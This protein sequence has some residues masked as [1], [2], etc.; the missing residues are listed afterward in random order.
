[1]KPVSNLNY[2]Y[3]VAFSNPKC[4]RA[5][6]KTIAK[7]KATSILEIGLG[8]ATRAEKIVRI[9]K[10]YSG[11]GAVRYTGVDGFES[12]PHQKIT[13][14]ECHQKLQD[15]DVKLQLV[16]G[17]IYS[18]L[19]RIA[20]SH[21]R[22]DIVIISAGYDPQALVDSWFYMPRMLHATSKV[23]VQPHDDEMG[24]FEVLSRLEIE[25]KVKSQ[26]RIM[27]RAA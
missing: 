14:K 17:E 12:Q 25:R 4:N 8:D 21:M 6:Y 18:S 15:P 1:M 24:S 13:L 5:I 10:R 26:P 7:N 20:N 19:N 22:T 3:L 23:F 11:S 16:P 9:A 2:F 27:S